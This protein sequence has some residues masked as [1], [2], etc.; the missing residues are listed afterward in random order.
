MKMRKVRLADGSTVEVPAEVADAFEQGGGARH[1]GGYQ[2]TDAEL[3]AKARELK[4]VVDSV[5]QLYRADVETGRLAQQL[6][7]VTLRELFRHEFPEKKWMNAGLITLSTNVDEGATEF[8]YVESVHSGEA[9]IVADNATDIPAAEVTG[10]NNLRAVKTVA[11][12]VTYSTQD[13]RSARLQGL[14]DIATEKAVAAR[15][16]MDLKLNN[17]IRTGD[18]AAGLRGITNAPGIVVQNAVNGDWQNPATTGEEIVTDVRTALNTIMNDTDAVEV[19][20]TVVFDVASWTAVSTRVHLPDASDR[21]IL[22][23]LREA[24]P[25]I[26]RW[27]WEPGMKTADAAG[28]GPAMLAYRNN[29]TR[30]RAVFPMMARA[31]PPQQAGLA[32]KLHFETRFGGVITPKPRSVLRLDGIGA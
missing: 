24:F 15:E 12:Y 28:T 13:L 11:D 16:A 26:Q 29:P 7:T 23:F 3:K 25:M 31:L 14:F 8:G 20:N 18:E 19:P 5:G 21:T 1:F 27:D 2:Y 9:A 17:L 10:R 32:F 30:V 6:V 22:S 4:M